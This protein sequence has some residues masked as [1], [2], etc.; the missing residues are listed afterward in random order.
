[1]LYADLLDPYLHQRLM[2]QGTPSFVGFMASH[3]LLLTATSDVHLPH[4]VDPDLPFVVVGLYFLS[5][6]V[7]VRIDASGTV[8]ACNS[9]VGP[10]DAEVKR[11]ARR[12]AY[13]LS[14][15]LF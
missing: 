9:L 14:D 6:F 12:A 8:T 11:T 3:Q 1:M 4:T 2:E 13:I 5:H 7:S 15:A 10:Y